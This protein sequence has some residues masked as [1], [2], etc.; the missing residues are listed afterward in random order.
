MKKTIC[1]LLLVTF[2]A[3][4]NMTGFGKGVRGSGNRQTEKRNVPDFLGLDVS[5][6]F[7]VEIVSQKERSL[8]ITGDDNIL[9]LVT[10]EVRGNVLHIGSN[11]S[12]S[13][14]R[15]ITIKVGVP[16]LRGVSSSGASKI[17]VSGIKGSVFDVDSSGASNI[18]LMGEAKNL[19][20]DTSGA[21]NIEAKDLHAE[22]VEVQSSG[23]GYV[24]VYAT[25]QLKASASGAARVDYYGDPSS[26]KPEVSGAGSVNKK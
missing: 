21:S 1:L 8:E 24:S 17:N 11:K 20:I 9:P 12:Y 25:L 22:S 14:N 13:V 3:G 2:A 19:R 4:C 6:A 16:E 26:V 7:E 23:A 10:T 5:G 18:S 15:P